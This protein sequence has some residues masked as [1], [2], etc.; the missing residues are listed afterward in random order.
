MTVPIGRVLC[1]VIVVVD[2]ETEKQLQNVE[3]LALASFTRKPGVG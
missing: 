1:V 2:V 3:I